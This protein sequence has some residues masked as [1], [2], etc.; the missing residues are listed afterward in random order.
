VTGESV[1]IDYVDQGY[2]GDD[3]D[4]DAASYGIT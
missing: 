1:E 2:I 3:P 4:V